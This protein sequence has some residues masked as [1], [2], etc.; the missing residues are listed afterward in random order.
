MIWR[1][2]D[3]KVLFVSKLPVEIWWLVFFFKS[4]SVK[5]LTLG[6]G[7]EFKSRTFLLQ[8]KRIQNLNVHWCHLS[9]LMFDH[10]DN[11]VPQSFMS[12][13]H[14]LPTDSSHGWTPPSPDGKALYTDHVNSS[15]RLHH[16]SPRCLSYSTYLDGVWSFP[17]LVKSSLCLLFSISFCKIF[18]ATLTRKPKICFLFMSRL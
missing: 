5:P 9:L 15:R 11:L 4:T 12:S 14:A 8:E 10:G 1:N 2:Q 17:L 13:E 18:S 6:V 16:P 7:N 3:S